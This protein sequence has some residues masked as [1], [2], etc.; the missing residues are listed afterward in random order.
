MTNAHGWTLKQYKCIQAEISQQLKAF[1]LSKRGEI[2]SKQSYLLQQIAALSTVVES[3]GQ[4]R[5]FILIMYTLV[6]HEKYNGIEE[7]NIQRLVN[8]AYA[9]LQVN[10]IKPRSSRFS[11]LYGDLHLI[12]SQIYR[13]GGQLWNS[14][15]EHKIASHLHGA[16]DAESKIVQNLSLA[17][18]L[19]SLG[20]IQQTIAILESLGLAAEHPQYTLMQAYYLKCLRLSGNKKAVLDKI[21]N[22]YPHTTDDNFRCELQWEFHLVQAAGNDLDTLMAMVSPKGSHF[23]R[24]YVLEGYL[25]AYAVPTTRWF[26]VFLKERTLRKRLNIHRS[27]KVF[28][29]LKILN[30]LY[31]GEIP[32]Y[33]RL[34]KAGRLINQLD[35]LK[36]VVLRM[37]FIV[38]VSRWLSR[39]NHY[40]M[41]VVVLEEYE[42][43]SFRITKGQ[44]NDCLNIAGDLFN[45]AW[46]NNVN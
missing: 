16:A 12:L 13:N 30:E 33:H 10:G 3:S 34:T 27:C 23:H 5:R 39:N 26:S 36:D 2:K 14:A 37:L 15:W 18:R 1:D 25:W 6:H 38:A 29:S 20:K 45:K 42:A 11:F 9:L 4:M 17:I 22:I 46:V 31:D 28:S 24:S 21:K 35:K 41:A 43:L 40:R 19:Y 8:L 7:R 44:S 32:F